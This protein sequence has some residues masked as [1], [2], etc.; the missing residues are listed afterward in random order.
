MNTASQQSCAT[1]NEVLQFWSNQAQLQ[2]T[3]SEAVADYLYSVRDNR[4]APAQ[5]PSGRHSH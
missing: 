2:R 4:P 1:D 5:D 3:A